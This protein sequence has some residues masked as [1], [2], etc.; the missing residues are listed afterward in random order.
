MTRWL[1]PFAALLLCL[2]AV[3]YIQRQQDETRASFPAPD[4]SLTDLHGRS[5]RLSNYRGKVVFLN[6]WATWCPPCREEMPSME[7]LYRRLQSESFVMLAVSQD[8]DPAGSV[9]PFVEQLR[10]SF[11]ILLD[12]DGKVPPK[13]GVTGY[14]ETFVIDRSGSV[15]D[16]VI[17]PRK[18]DSETSY[19]YFSDLLSQTTNTE[20]AAQ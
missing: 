12:P 6:L 17:G 15:I 11:P 9:R 8:E 19:R 20:Q 14:P 18:W 13:Y 5:H 7:H 3:V 4:F 1:I 10:L 2:S 16:H